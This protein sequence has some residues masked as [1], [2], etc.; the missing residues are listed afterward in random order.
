MMRQ[1]A[2]VYTVF[3]IVLYATDPVKAVQEQVITGICVLVGIYY[4][5]FRDLDAMP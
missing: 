5:F 3:C 1:M 4:T 2:F